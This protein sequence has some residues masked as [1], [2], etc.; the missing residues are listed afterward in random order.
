M[1]SDPYHSSR[2]ADQILRYVLDYKALHLYRA[3]NL[4]IW[5]SLKTDAWRHDGHPSAHMNKSI[6]GIV[7]RDCVH[8]CL[9]GVPDAW[10]EILLAFL[11]QNY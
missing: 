3:A 9:P 7:I 5:N 1:A 4:K 10:S 2:T 6:D 11:F 8:W